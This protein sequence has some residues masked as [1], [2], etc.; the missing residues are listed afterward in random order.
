[1]H[2]REEGGRAREKRDEG[3]KRRKEGGGGGGERSGGGRSKEGGGR[4][5]EEGREEE[6]GEH[7]QVTVLGMRY[8]LHLFCLHAIQTQQ[9]V[10]PLFHGV[11]RGIPYRVPE[12]NFAECPSYPRVRKILKYTLENTRIKINS[13]YNR[14]GRSRNADEGGRREEWRRAKGQ[15]E[16]TCQK[17]PMAKTKNLPPTELFLSLIPACSFSS[18]SNFKDKDLPVPS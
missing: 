4:R 12:Y 18:L 6:G 17:K 15:K 13:E 14:C 11:P 5:R 16:R 7:T 10:K 3:G 8:R 9:L 1:M 2:R